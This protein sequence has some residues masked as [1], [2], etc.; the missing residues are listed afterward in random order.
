VPKSREAGGATLCSAKRGDR[1]SPKTAWLVRWASSTLLLVA[2]I[3]ILS[4]RSPHQGV[5]RWV[6]LGS[7]NSTLSFPFP[8]RFLFASVLISSV[9][10]TLFFCRSSL[11]AEVRRTLADSTPSNT[12]WMLSLL[13]YVLMVAEL[14][15]WTNDGAG[16]D[17]VSA[18]YILREAILTIAVLGS[19][20]LAAMPLRFWLRWTKQ[21]LRVIP[22]IAAMG[23]LTYVIG[24]HYTLLVLRNLTD[25]ID[26]IERSTLYMVSFFLRLCGENP[27][28]DP[29]YNLI[30]IANFSVYI[31]ASCA[32]WEGIGLFCTFF[33]VYLWLY[34]RDLRFPQALILLP[35]GVLVLWCLNVVRLVALILLGNWSDAL[36]VD[37]FHSVAGWLFFNAATLGLVIASRRLRLFAQNGSGH[38]RCASSNPVKPY[39]LPLIII[40]GT[41]MLTRVFSYHFDILYPLRVVVGASALWFYRKKLPLRWSP[42][43]SAVALGFLAFAIWIILLD[44][45]NNPAATNAS[46]RIGLNSLSAIGAASWILFRIIGAVL[47]VPIAEELAFRGY[48][49]R[50]LVSAD[51]EAVAPGH[52]TWPSFLG[53]SILFGALH[54]E[55][56]AGTIAGMIFAL[57][58]YRRGSFSDAITSHSVANGMLA[59]Y[60]LATGRWFLWN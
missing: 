5:I 14:A 9:L 60:V 15:K 45:E 27:V 47:I 18:T 32:G 39:L 13:I 10:A 6:Q 29:R 43:W 41:A 55:W 42:S 22:A 49:I 57:A 52:F 24:N 26:P 16:N 3:L 38:D 21:N 20:C 1:A 37:G 28:F 54:V 36:A 17:V 11:R 2:G 4:V 23:I 30:G 34:R 7:S 48:I 12:K 44:R 56:L 53:S 19:A 40:I 35:I 51:F 33:S 58:V 46:I 25:F 8:N 59:V 31:G 50:K